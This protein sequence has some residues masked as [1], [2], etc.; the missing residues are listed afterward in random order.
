MRQI[1]LRQHAAIDP[2]RHARLDLH[3]DRI[4]NIDLGRCQH[5]EQF[6]MRNN[7][8]TTTGQFLRYTLIDIDTPAVLMK[9]IRRKQPT[10]RTAYHNGC[11]TRGKGNNGHLRLLQMPYQAP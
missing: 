9:K 5:I 7:A 2:E 1:A 11:W 4:V 3:A 6:G 10:E 8:S